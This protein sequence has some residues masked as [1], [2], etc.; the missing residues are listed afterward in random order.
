MTIQELKNTLTQVEQ[1]VFRMEDGNKI[2]SHFHITEVGQIEK[3]FIDCGGTV[4]HE[5]KASLQLWESIDVWHR[6]EPAK[7]LKIIELSEQKIALENVEIEVEYQGQSISKFALQFDGKEFV[8]KNIS[9]ACLATDACGI[10]V[11]QLKQKFVDL[12]EQIVSCCS[13]N[14]GCC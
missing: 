12:K 10:G 8:L 7:L 6:L 11:D 2:P 5:K 4:R 13:P 3:R 9:T 1:L 14:S